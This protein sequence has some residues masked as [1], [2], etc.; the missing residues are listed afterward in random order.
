MNE[1][2]KEWMKEKQ[3]WTKKINI[4][5]DKFMMRNGWNWI[6]KPNVYKPNVEMVDWRNKPK[7]EWIKRMMIKIHARKTVR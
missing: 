6:H 3:E 5:L 7:N 2:T 1:K 4:Q